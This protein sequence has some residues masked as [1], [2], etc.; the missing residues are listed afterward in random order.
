M[1]R[2][3]LTLI[4]FFFLQQ[5][6]CGSLRKSKVLSSGLTCL[7]KGTCVVTHLLSTCDSQ[8]CEH[9]VIDCKH[10]WSE[11][12]TVRVVCHHVHHLPTRTR[13]TVYTA[14]LITPVLPTA[15]SGTRPHT[16]GTASCSGCP[17][18]NIGLHTGYGVS[19]S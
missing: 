8:K 14:T 11:A 17:D 9:Q 18:I 13:S 12:P 1:S 16:D 19:A 5:S 10:A 4:I 2:P 15:D 7:R 3:S 6:L